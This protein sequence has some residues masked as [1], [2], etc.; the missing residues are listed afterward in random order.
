MKHKF[1]IE[2]DDKAPV[3]AD[4]PAYTTVR[5]ESDDLVVTIKTEANLRIPFE[6]IREN[7]TSEMSLATTITALAAERMALDFAIDILPQMAQ[8]IEAA[9]NKA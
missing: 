5:E 3:A 8:A 1:V 9:L 4:C 6:T 2:Y 7:A